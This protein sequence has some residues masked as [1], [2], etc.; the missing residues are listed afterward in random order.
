MEVPQQLRWILAVDVDDRVALRGDERKSG[1]QDRVIS[2]IPREGDHLDAVVARTQHADPLEAPVGA[3][4]VHE[5]D[6]PGDRGEGFEDGPRTLVERRDV[7]DL[8]VHRDDDR[9][10]AVHFADADSMI[11]GRLRYWAIRW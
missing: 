2:K 9:E 10:T 1:E 7:S 6:L 5:D 3:P 4:V 11:D 8:V